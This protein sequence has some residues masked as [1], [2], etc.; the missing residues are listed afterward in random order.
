[1]KKELI[2]IS[3][4]T[5]Y[6]LIDILEQVMADNSIPYAPLTLAALTPEGYNIK[7]INRRLLWRRRDFVEGALVGITC[8]TSTVNEAYKLADKF[9]RAG[10]R[11]VLGGPH[12]S[13]LPEEALAH[14]D[15]VV[16]G[17][18]ESVW[19]QVVSDFE[20]DRLAPIYKGEPL[21][22]FFTPVY[23]YLMKIDPSAL[24]RTGLQIDRGCKYHCDFCAR[25]SNWV[26]TVKI[27]QVLSLV[28]RIK[29]ARRIFFFRRPSIGFRCD[30]IYSNPAYAKKLFK[31]LAPF[32]VNWGANASI[33]IGFDEEALQLAQ[34]S[35]CKKLFIGFETRYPE[36]YKKTS[37]QQLHSEQD[38][39]IAIKNIKA[40][41]I[42]IVGS[43]IIGLD[44]YHNADYLK[45][46]LFL[47]RSG[48]WHFM[49]TILTPFPGSEL[50]DRLKKEERILSYNWAKYNFYFC[51]IRPK[52]T[53][54]GAVYAWYW[55][56]RI[57][58]SFFS[59][60]LYEIWLALFVALTVVSFVY[61][62]AWDLG[63]RL[64]HGF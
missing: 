42:K 41:K 7:I 24:A 5:S 2:L 36:D 52:H 8:L 38:Y 14:A 60:F 33:D 59:P 4:S 61:D 63:M 57:V 25:V 51:V 18:A 45:L 49:L 43:F 31:E 32:E 37:L 27:E 3:P 39:K 26:R 23:D 48:L 20:Q 22:D 47:T 6:H 56:I 28:E 15:S 29:T 19:A 30:N 53:S 44:R 40:H 12:A 54:V 34:A 10:S 21:E 62:R 64:F 17:E 9:R 35:G 1:M 16:T 11:V 13:A 46:L 58:I 50:F 55:L